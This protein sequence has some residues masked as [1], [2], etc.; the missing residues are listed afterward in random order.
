MP[1]QNE[2]EW[3]IFRELADPRAAAGLAVWLRNEQI[4]ARVDG[5]AVFIPRSQRHRAGWIVSHLPPS[6]DDLR[7]LAGAA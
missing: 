4:A 2:E 1:V 6:D 5:N 3:M 7:L